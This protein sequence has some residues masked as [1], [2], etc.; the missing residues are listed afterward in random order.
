MNDHM[1]QSAQGEIQK[2]WGD[3]SDGEKY[4]TAKMDSF[5]PGSHRTRTSL[6]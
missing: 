6:S 3:F 4:Q 2:V 1:I 5:R